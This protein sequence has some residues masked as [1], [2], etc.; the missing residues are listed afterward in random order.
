MVKNRSARIF[1]TRAT[2]TVRRQVTLPV[3]AAKQLAMWASEGNG[4]SM[5]DGR[6][7]LLFACVAIASSASA[8]PTKAHRSRQPA[9]TKPAAPS[10]PPVAAPA[11]L[12][13]PKP[14]GSPGDWFPPE[15][16]PSAAKVA[17]QEG[18][19]EFA[20]DVDAAGR[21]MTC[22]IVQSSGSELLDSTTC[23]QLILNGRF[24]PARDAS[25][26]PVASKWHSA[27]RWRLVQGGGEEE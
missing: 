3:M 7:M 10:A 4:A 9:V 17:G 24:E 16:Y 21:I 14:I 11:E 26:K 23:S 1:K 8:L 6:K 27:M 18:R 20:L 15:S 12:P 2:A 25:G 5:I 19:T 13:Q 22:N